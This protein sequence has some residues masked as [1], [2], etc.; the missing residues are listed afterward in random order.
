MGTMGKLLLLFTASLCLYLLIALLESIDLLMNSSIGNNKQAVQMQR[1]ALTKPMGLTPEMFIQGFLSSGNE[2][3]KSADEIEPEKLA[4][5]IRDTVMRIVRKREEKVVT[6][7]AENF[8][9][10]FLGLLVNAYHESDKKS[11][12]SEQD[13]VDEYWQ[14][15]ARSEVLEVFGNRNPDSEGISKLKIVSISCLSLNY[16]MN[17]SVIMPWI[18]P[19]N[20]IIRKVGQEVRLGK[21]AL[22]TPLEII[23]R[24]IALHHDPD[25]WGANVHLFKPERFSQGVAKAT[26]YNAAAYLPFGFGP[27]SCFE[28]SFDL[29]LA[30]K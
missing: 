14:D 10:H 12:L 13:L 11:R 20:G 4:K 16:T 17:Y 27:R 1:E 21:L 3:W 8:G 25:L 22:P 23:I 18:P 24:I 6:G 30:L 5:T 19:V 2:I 29:D 26:N 28:M 15:K 9:H 7:E